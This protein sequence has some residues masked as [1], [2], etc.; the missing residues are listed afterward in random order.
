MSCSLL[1]SL[2]HEQ[3]Q[4]SAFRPKERRREE[5]L[6]IRHYFI[7][8]SVIGALRALQHLILT[9][10]VKRWMLLSL[11]YKCGN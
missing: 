10:A 6:L 5:A 7:T 9:V 4:P 1:C 11:F 2:Q 3:S 8:C